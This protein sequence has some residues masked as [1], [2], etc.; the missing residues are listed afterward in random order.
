VADIDL[1]TFIPEWCTQRSTRAALKL[2]RPMLAREYNNRIVELAR[3][4]RPDLFLAFKGSLVLSSTLRT[5]RSLGIALYNYYPDT[6]AMNHSG[7][8]TDT[9]TEYDCVFLGHSHLQRDFREKLGVRACSV[10]LHGYDP[11]VHR[12]WSLDSDEQVRYGADV[13]LIAIHSPHKQSV[14]EQLLERRPN[15]NLRIWG[16][17]WHLADGSQRLKAA[18]QGQAIVGSAYAKA[19]CASKINLAIMNGLVHGASVG[20]DTTT[21]T[22]EIPAC[23]GF[24]LHER[25]SELLDLYKEDR[26]VAA[27]DSPDELAGKVDY[28]LSHPIERDA[29]ARAGH[30]RCVP[31]YSYEAR[32]AE[33]VS[34]HLRTVENDTV[35]S[36]V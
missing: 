29:L 20:D 18:I 13:T 2:V 34:W 7:V 25:T 32:M 17:Q 14:V 30:D 33:V 28:Y 36:K 21:R 11:E 12:S 26:E 4:I 15:L 1:Q 35:G 3:L 5:L 24:M 10:L 19:I 8:R 9:L 22:F 16:N 6:S 31:S 23:G 27:F